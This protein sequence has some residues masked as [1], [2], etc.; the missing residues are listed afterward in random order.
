LQ[1]A[2]AREVMP[3]YLETVLTACAAPLSSTPAERAL[4]E[5]LTPRE[6]DVLELLAAGLT[7]R[8]IAAR[9][10]VSPETVKKHVAHICGKLGAGNRTEAAARARELR[11]LD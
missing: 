9:L 8:E 2:H 3:A 7:N 10:A 6:Q 5:P 4:P 11:L 1:E